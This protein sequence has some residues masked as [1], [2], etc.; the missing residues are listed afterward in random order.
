MDDK[1]TAIQEFKDVLEAQHSSCVFSRDDEYLELAIRLKSEGAANELDSLMDSPAYKNLIASLPNES[2]DKAVEC[3]CAYR[4]AG[5]LH[6]RSCPVY[7]WRRKTRSLER[8]W[9]SMQVRI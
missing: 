8:L 3:E 7:K 1:T 5:D 4:G 9:S 2:N 6:N